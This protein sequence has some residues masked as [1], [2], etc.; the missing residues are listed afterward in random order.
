MRFF[1]IEEGYARESSRSYSVPQNLKSIVRRSVDFDQRD[2]QNDKTRQRCDY[3]I[4][5][6]RKVD[7]LKVSK[8]CMLQSIMDDMMGNTAFNDDVEFADVK[9]HSE[10][11]GDDDKDNKW[12]HIIEMT[13]LQKLLQEEE[14][15]G[16]LYSGPSSHEMQQWRQKREEENRIN[17]IAIQHCF[18]GM[19][20][21]AV[22]PDPKPVSFKVFMIEY[23]S[24]APMVDQ[25]CFEVA[26]RII[27][28]DFKNHVA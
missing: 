6:T 12:A 22:L 23:L 20:M 2:I 10:V 19:K 3:A 24:T 16:R 4:D 26:W 8:I 1:E 18:A 11:T 13:K 21:F 17:K 14:A 15:M 7:L 27:K 28:T 5:K 9:S 25:Q